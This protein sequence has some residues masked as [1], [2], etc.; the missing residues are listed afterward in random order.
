VT[1]VKA[2]VSPTTAQALCD[3][4]G[5]ST[6]IP[7]VA[8]A[9]LKFKLRSVS[10]PLTAVTTDAF[11]TACAEFYDQGLPDCATDVTC[12]ISSRRLLLGQEQRLRALQMDI[13]VPVDVTATFEGSFNA[14]V[15]DQLV[16]ELVE[17]NSD[18]FITLLQTS[19]T[20]PE[21][22]TFFQSV[23]V[24]GF[25]PTDV[26]PSSAPSPVPT[27]SVGG[28]SEPTAA[29]VLAMGMGRGMKGMGMMKMKMMMGMGMGMNS[30][31]M[32]MNVVTT[33]VS[34]GMEM[35]MGIN[36]A[37]M[38]MADVASNRAWESFMGKLNRAS[39]V[40]QQDQQNI[41]DADGSSISTSAPVASPTTPSSITAWTKFM[42]QLNSNN[43]ND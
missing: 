42:E 25:E 20:N 22:I 1:P 36:A 5:N 34:T 43:N 15:F 9:S 39:T 37:G 8:T 28:I 14:S 29:P 40:Q 12:D 26:A 4:S 19:S 23:D 6:A 35:R 38:G 30:G 16:F 11:L 41:N 32:G 7:V 24:E 27:V 10:G 21:V 31:A 13:D 3:A 2:P 18:D 17:T 33:N